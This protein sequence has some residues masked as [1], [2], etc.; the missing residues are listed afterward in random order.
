MHRPH[1]NQGK[2]KIKFLIEKKSKEKKLFELKFRK[3]NL[4]NYK[5]NA[6]Q[7]YR[8]WANKILFQE[9]NYLISLG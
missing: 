7:L 4:S 1:L 2:F 5:K 8:N 6:S 9:K 3:K